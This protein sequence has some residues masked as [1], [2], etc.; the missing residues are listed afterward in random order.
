MGL[1]TF[2]KRIFSRPARPVLPPVPHPVLPPGE[3]GPVSPEIEE[4]L[5]L[6]NVLRE[7]RGESP[8]RMDLRL[9]HAAEGQARDV[10]D[11]GWDRNAH[12]GSDG[13]DVMTRV[14]RQGYPVRWVAENAVPYPSGWPEPDTPQEAMKAWVQS[15][16][17]LANILAPEAQEFGAAVSRVPSGDSVWIA[18]FA[19]R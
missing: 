19:A 2:F 9:V 15:P 7:G 10:A 3:T 1:A 8:L 13:S 11:R 4:L 12:R 14:M 6:H 18:V 5:R 16:G 17:H